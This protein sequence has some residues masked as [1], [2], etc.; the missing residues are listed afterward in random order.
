M[1]E[2]GQVKSKLLILLIYPI[3][4]I[5]ARLI[6]IYFISNPSFYLFLFFISH[7]LALIPLLIYKIG[8]NISRKRI[9]TQKII[10]NIENQTSSLSSVNEASDEAKNQIELLKE[11]I[12][13]DNKKYKILI[14]FL[15]GFLYFATYVFFYYFNYISTA[16]DFYGNIS[17]VTEV[18]YF[19]LFNR[20]VLGNKIYS[21]HFL[22]MIIIT[23]SI[24]G[25]YII[26]IIQYISKN[27]GNYDSFKDFIFPTILNFI[28]YCPFCYF[29]IK[30]KKYIEKYFISIY[31]LLVYLGLLCLG[32]LFIFEPISFLISC[33]DNKLII[34]YKGHFAGIISGFKDLSKIN[35]VYSLFLALCLFMTSLG[36]WLTVKIL[37]PVDFLTSDSIITVELNILVDSQ[38]LDHLLICNPLFYIFS[39]MAI[40]GC[41]I[42]N[43]IIIINIF[44]LNYNT[45]IE[46]IKRQSN[47]LKCI[48]LS[49]CE[50]RM[51]RSS[52]NTLEEE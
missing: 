43:E 22:S 42:Y 23:I 37:S 36:L 44:N 50:T 28:V 40:F 39:L 17:M 18:L 52:N 46:I 3:G 6:T 25:I 2:F 32:L 4:I 11:K 51:S 38:N 24:L 12:K 5:F 19:T 26:L 30:S 8:K 9:K 29:L 34:C 20:I 13:K 1:I 48:E 47:D 15:I 49:G 10:N 21:H 31:E 14:F 16:K 33:K 7:F 45:R 35:A 41:L 27:N